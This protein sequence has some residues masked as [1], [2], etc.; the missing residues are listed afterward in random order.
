MRISV[1]ILRSVCAAL[2]G[3]ALLLTPLAANAADRGPSTPEERKQALEYIH[4]WQA[5]PLGPRAKD[6][7][8][9]VLKW[10]AEV[11]DQTVHV[12]MI[13]DKLPKG[14]KKDSSTI[15]GGAFMAQAA[16]VL[17]NPDKNSDAQAEY[18][19]GV[20]GALKIYETLLNA[21]PKDRQPY[22]DDLIQRREAGT[23]AQWVK[24]HSGS[25]CHQ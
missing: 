4:S 7:F 25:G 17:E 16:F 11:P 14:D 13:L 21:N 15:F 1:M 18:E 9:W 24:E 6:Q 20:E 3:C 22:L 5:D 10:F 12:C 19:A 2:V 23:L 8:G